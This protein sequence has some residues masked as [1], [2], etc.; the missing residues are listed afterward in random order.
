MNS[1]PRHILGSPLALKDYQ[2]QQQLKTSQRVS[3]ALRVNS[4][5][6]KKKNS[7]I[8]VSSHSLLQA[9]NRETLTERR[10][11]PVPE[12]KPET[13]DESPKRMF[14]DNQSVQF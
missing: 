12:P 2:E 4:R 7:F 9:Q 5:L 8:H 13:K 3:P 14:I 11:Q 1:P 6:R 10:E